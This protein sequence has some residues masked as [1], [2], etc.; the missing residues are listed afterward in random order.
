VRRGDKVTWDLMNEMWPIERRPHHLQ[1][2]SIVQ[3]LSLGKLMRYKEIYEK[4]AEKQGLGAALYG[5][6]QKAKKQK[7]K[8]ATDDGHTKLH[9][10]R[11]CR[12]P[13]V[14]P[15]KY[16][17][18]VPKRRPEIYRHFPLDHYGADNQVSEQTVVRMHDRQVPVDLD[19]FVRAGYLK[20]GELCYLWLQQGLL[21]YAAIMHSL[22][23]TDYSPHVMLRILAECKWGEAAGGDRKQQ[24]ELVK[25]FFNDIAREN[26]GRA[27]RGE[28]PLDYAQ[29]RARWAKGL[30]SMYPQLAVLTSAVCTKA[31]GSNGGTAAGN[32]GSSGGGAGSGG[33]GGG[34]GGNAGGLRGAPP[35][36]VNG[37][38]VCYAFNQAA[39]CTGRDRQ[40]P[41]ACKAKNGTVYAHYCNWFDTK[42]GKHCLKQ[43]SRASSH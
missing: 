17:K 22:W 31:G 4:E 33:K 2:R 34:K 21:N 30:E 27:V 3:K 11:F 29:C 8:A 42:S 32:A 23:P 39:G 20:G 28:A 10:A 9:K 13:L 41:H 40:G 5:K 19:A 7:F 25:R 14:Q 18:M 36:K 43:H 15:K 6:D 24:M 38:D 26:S 37:L 12:L 35:A 1:N 16:Y